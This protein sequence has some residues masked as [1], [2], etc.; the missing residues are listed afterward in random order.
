MEP[1]AFAGRVAWYTSTRGALEVHPRPAGNPGSVIQL[2]GGPKRPHS[3]R[4]GPTRCG[5]ATLEVQRPASAGRTT[6]HF[7]RASQSG[8]FSGHGSEL[9]TG[10]GLPAPLQRSCGQGCFGCF[11][12][13]HLAPMHNRQTFEAEAVTVHSYRPVDPNPP[14]PR[15]VSLSSAT[16]TTLTWTRGLITICAIFIPASTANAVCPWLI[17]I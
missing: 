1:P 10:Q 2:D 4:T 5:R 8:G 11:S 15:W 16:S 12:H 7:I 3:R 14:A 17:R 13:T 6:R 9:Q